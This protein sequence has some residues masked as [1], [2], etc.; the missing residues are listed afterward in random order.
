MKPIT[1]VIVSD[2][3]PIISSSMNSNTPALKKCIGDFIISRNKEL[4]DSG[5]YARIYFGKPELDN[6]FSS[7]KVTEATILEKLQNAFF[8]DVA[9]NPPQIKEAFTVAM[10]C[11]IRHFLIKNDMK[12]VEISTIYL[13]FSG[14][15]YASVHG[16][17][18]P[19]FPPSE[20]RPVMEYVINQKLSEKFDLRREGTLFGAIKSLCL[21]WINTY[22]DIIKSKNFDD[23]EC[24]MVI[25]QLRDREKSFIINIAVLYYVSYN[26]KEYINYESDNLADGDSYRLADSDSLRA[27]KLSEN[28]LNYIVG[29]DVDYAVI[30]NY[31]TDQ[32]VKKDEIRD[33]LESIFNDKNNLTDIKFVINVLITDFIKNNKGKPLTGID[34]ITYS[35]RTKPNTKDPNLLKLK[36]TILSWLDENS[37]Q[38]RKRKGRPETSISYYKCVLNYFV[39]II[40]RLAK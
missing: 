17:S 38:Y 1:K 13:A 40:N 9:Y 15:F 35:I 16:N 4:Y 28:V 21:T 31:C 25:Q 36:K 26:N 14:K 29:H 12:M 10:L 18:F 34:F 23:Q 24:G 37:A 39:I 33:I 19:K 27:E 6:F 7:I 3:Y 30:S 2:I 5:P 32:N 22:K 8:F 20:H 11:I